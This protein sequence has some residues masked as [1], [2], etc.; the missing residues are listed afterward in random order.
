[1]VIWSDVVNHSLPVIA[2]LQA[3]SPRKIDFSRKIEGESA[4]S[5]LSYRD[6]RKVFQLSASFISSRTSLLIYL[7]SGDSSNYDIRV[8][9]WFNV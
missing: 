5:F 8:S 6:W 9:V 7:V 1:M 4:H 2:T 3:E